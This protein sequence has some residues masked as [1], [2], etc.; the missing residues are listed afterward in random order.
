MITVTTRRDK[1]QAIAAAYDK[2]YSRHYGEPFLAGGRDPYET[3]LALR[4]LNLATCTP[5]EV[6]AVMGND[7]WTELKCEHCEEPND[8]L[9][10]LAGPYETVSLCPGCVNSAAQAIEAR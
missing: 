9:V 7:S 4:K 5:A 1:I 10:T 3:T 8:L 2:Q 6:D